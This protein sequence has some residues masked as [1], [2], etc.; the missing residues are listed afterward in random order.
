MLEDVY[1]VDFLRTPFSRFSR[2]EPQ[3]DVFYNIRPEELAGM[4]IDEL[5]KRSNINPQDIDELITGCA[6]QVGE[7]W[8]YGG[9][10]EVFGAKLPYT[11]P[12][13][14]V[15]RQCASSL[16]S[17]SIGA[18]EISTGMADIVIAGGVEKM[19]KVPMY[20]NPHIEINPKFL[21]DP[22]Y[23]EYDLAIGYVMGLTAEKLAEISG[24]TREEMD[25][26]SLRSHQL[27]YKAI[28]EG[29]FTKEIVPIEVEIEGK[30]VQITQDQ[31]VR[32]D[33]SLE[34]LLQLPPAFKPNGVITAG[35]SA[36][37][38][39]GASYVLLMSKN[40]L[41]KYGLEP[42][43][44]IRSFGYAGV[45]PDIMGEGPVP[46]SKKALEKAKLSVKD[47]D[48]W[49]IN[50]A[51]AVVVLN[52][53]KKLDIDESKV[54]KRGGAIAIGHPLGA[55]GARLIGTLA[56]QLVLE[57]KDYGVATLCVG[58]G[59]GGAVVIERT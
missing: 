2:K 37:L 48:L 32:P 11:V 27:A 44:K 36:P 58:G 46:A 7:Q 23:A 56:R 53:I 33:T 22:K 21:T 5:I 4:V 19:S 20:D 16:S 38:N 55:T 12:A 18:M 47:I 42:M 13:L 15:D 50:E 25:R 59:Q 54:N 35:N 9:R 10:H 14:A 52:A 41:K 17:V 1:I 45:P 26:F 51:F 8:A 6:L 29:Y 24:I 43:A 57:G 31:S 39:S 49:E 3:K 34:K 40:A 28:Q 30:K